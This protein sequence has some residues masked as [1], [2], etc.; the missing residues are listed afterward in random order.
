MSEE[1][2]KAIKSLNEFSNTKYGCFS[3]EEGKVILNLIEKQ[4]K[5][6]ERISSEFNIGKRQYEELIEDYEELNLK[7]IEQQKEIEEYKTIEKIEIDNENRLSEE[8]V[9]ISTMEYYIETNQ[10]MTVPEQENQLIAVK[11]ILNEK[12]KQI[13]NSVSKDK[14]REKLKELKQEGSY[15]SNGYYDSGAKLILEELLE[16]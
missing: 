7:N 8:E 10:V 16:E 9:L 4:Q 13:K 2:K 11:Y 3:A 6:I 5:E 12:N 14:I 15:F 1:E